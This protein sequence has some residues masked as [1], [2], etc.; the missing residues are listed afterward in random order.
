[1]SSRLSSN[2]Q[3]GFWERLMEL[4]LLQVLSQGDVKGLEDRSGEREALQAGRG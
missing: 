2:Q 1:M 3:S 4:V